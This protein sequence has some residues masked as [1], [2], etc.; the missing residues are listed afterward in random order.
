VRRR[1]VFGWAAC[2]VA[3][4]VASAAD[5]TA[6]RP[7][8]VRQV[9][10]STAFQIWYPDREDATT[11]QFDHDVLVN[12]NTLAAGEYTLKLFELN[13]KSIRVAFSDTLQAVT[14]EFA[15]R[16]EESAEAERLRIAFTD[17]VEGVEPAAINDKLPP[18][19]S[20]ATIMIEWAG[21]EAYMHFVM[22]GLCRRST[23][24]PDIPARFAEPW[25]IVQASLAALLDE[26]VEN[27][28]VRFADDLKSELVFGKN[29]EAH[30]RFLDQSKTRGVLEGALLALDGLEW[31]E[32]EDTVVFTGIVVHAATHSMPFTYEVERRGNEW[33]VTRLGLE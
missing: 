23:P 3:A 4:I 30:A 12:G 20:T 31:H 21:R 24:A 9:V 16:S 26:D 19:P 32:R 5:G 15:V 8:D 17:V 1:I 33:K 29:V 18:K 13:D 25:S 2:T 27:H 14:L 11:F 22:T 10:G 28:I 7:P 6:R